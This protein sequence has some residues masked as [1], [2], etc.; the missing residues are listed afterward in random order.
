MDWDNARMFLAVYRQGTLRGAAEVLQVDP[1][2]VGRRLA[3]LEQSLAAKLFLRKPSGY[4]ST[5][6]GELAFQA[7]ERMEQAANQL[8]RQMQGIDERLCGT[9]RVACTDTIAVFYL[10]DA[11]RDL[12]VRHPGIRLQLSASTRLTNLTRREADL[13]VRTARPDDPD[14]VVRHLA[15]GAYGLYASRMYLAERGE[16]VPGTAL[17]GHD[18]VMYQFAN[19]AY[20]KGYVSDEPAANATV[21]LE[22]NSGLMMLHALRAGMGIGQM[23]TYIGDADPTLDRVWPERSK[24]YDFWLVLH[25]DLNRTARVRA[26]V[27]TVV[28]AFASE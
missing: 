16:P 6:A 1:A 2:T 3:A 8:Q 14:L 13:A 5:P 12:R 11:F 15:R 23:S 20:P 22:V 7:A 26:V 9:V 17:A 24:P 21:A 10:I 27:D 25:G 18:V 4:V 28:A 19:S